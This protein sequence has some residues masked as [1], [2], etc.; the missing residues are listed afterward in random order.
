LIANGK[1][2][3][4]KIFQ[5]EQDEGTIVGEAN[6]KVFI[7]EYYKKLF[8]EPEQNHFSWVEENNADIPQLSIEQSNILTRNF[9]VEEVKD[10]IMQME[11]N[12]APGP[13]GFPTEFYQKFWDVIKP[14]L[15]AMF[16]Q[17]QSG[18]LPLF[19]LN[20]GIIIL[21]PKK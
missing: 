16:S 18:E 4:N 10:A 12:K 11:R 3:K 15:M 9:E 5:L 6:L 17:L 14:D 21:L 8:G 19:R 1:H 20:F 7:S 13:Y 2:R